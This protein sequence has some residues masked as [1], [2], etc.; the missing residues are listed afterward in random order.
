MNG[1][2]NGLFVSVWF[3]F[4]FENGKQKNAIITNLSASIL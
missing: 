1:T 4:L 2:V 3:L